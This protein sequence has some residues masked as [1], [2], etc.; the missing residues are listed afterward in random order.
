MT[1]RA[2]LLHYALVLY[3]H[4]TQSH[5]LYDN[6]GSLKLILLNVH[7]YNS[8]YTSLTHLEATEANRNTATSLKVYFM[9]SLWQNN[10]IK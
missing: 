3:I 5:H 4:R 6:T 2:F 1:L 10:K 9:D 8:I 7:L